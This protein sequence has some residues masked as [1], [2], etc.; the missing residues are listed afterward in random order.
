MNRRMAKVICRIFASLS[1][2]FSVIF[3]LGGEGRTGFEDVSSGGEEM[4]WEIAVSTGFGGL[5]RKVIL[6]EEV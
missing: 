6:A 3:V 5:R 2:W 1:S 4:N